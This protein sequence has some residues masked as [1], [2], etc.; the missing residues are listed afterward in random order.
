MNTDRYLILAYV[1][2]VMGNEHDA[3]ARLK[4]AATLTANPWRW[5]RIRKAIRLLR[6]IMRKKAYCT[7]GLMT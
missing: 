1:S 2:I 7:L 5:L 6:P 4:S 3:I